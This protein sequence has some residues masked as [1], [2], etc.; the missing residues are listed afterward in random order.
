IVVDTGGTSALPLT[1]QRLEAAGVKPSEVRY[2]L[3]SHSH[4]DHAGAAYL[5]RTRGAKIVAPATAAFTVTWTMPTWSDYSIWVPAPIDV[6]LALRRAGDTKEVTLSGQ[7]IKAI[8]APG[9]SFDSVL[10]LLELNGKRIVFT[11]DIGFE[12]GS[13]ILHRCWGD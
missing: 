6:P 4:G 5:W 3:L 7:R 11:G 9:H 12:G 10:Y 1:W 2:V 13:H 8:F